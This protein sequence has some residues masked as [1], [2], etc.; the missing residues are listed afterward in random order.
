METRATRER[1]LE[2]F[3]RLAEGGPDVVSLL[4]KVDEETRDE[5]PTPAF[6]A[7]LRKRLDADTVAAAIDL[8]TARRKAAG[9]FPDASGLWADPQAV[10]QASS[11]AVAAWKAKRFGGFPVADR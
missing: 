1:R 2:A 8:V 3:R 7:G 6:V 11:A 4:A 10:E 9:K 5:G